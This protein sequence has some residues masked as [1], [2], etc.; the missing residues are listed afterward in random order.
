MANNPTGSNLKESMKSKEVLKSEVTQ[1]LNLVLKDKAIE[2]FLKKTTSEIF[3]QIIEIFKKKV[4][5]K[6][7]EFIANVDK[8][9]IANDFFETCDV[10]DEKRELKLREQINP[11]IKN[12]QL[13][14]EKSQEKALMEKFGSSQMMSSNQGESGCSGSS[15]QF[16]E[17]S[18]Q[19]GES[20][21]QCGETGESKINQW[22]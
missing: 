19:C 16:G 17:S 20:S 7:E 10:L 4:N 5:E 6:L 2:D 15:S 9:K 14:E 11:Y 13:K 22:C 18:G 3:Q 12:L 1:K 8:N 21:G